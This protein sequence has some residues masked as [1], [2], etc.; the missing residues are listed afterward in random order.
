MFKAVKLRKVRLRHGLEG[1]PG[2]SIFRLNE[3]FLTAAVF[4]RVLYLPS[5]AMCALLLPGLS[6]SPGKV[7]E[8]AFWP[9]L[10]LQSKNAGMVRVEPDLC[11]QFE[12]LDLIVEAKLSDDPGCQTPGQWVREWVAW[13]QAERPDIEKPSLLLAIGG[14]GA[15]ETTSESAAIIGAEANRLLRIDFLG[16]PPIRWV[17]LSWQELYNRLESEILDNG[18]NSQLVEDLREILRYFGLRRRHFLGDLG[19]LARHLRIDRI[20]LVSLN[21][22]ARWQSCHRELAGVYSHFGRDTG[23]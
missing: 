13:H 8:S 16:V 15:F 21:V 12:G 11:V 17:A 23:K 1:L 22:A 7:K 4:S 20:E 18:P 3:D 14:L 19:G 10:S 2:A 5:E 6:V 9:T